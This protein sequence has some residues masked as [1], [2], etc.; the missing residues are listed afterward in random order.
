M[1]W[2]IPD[3]ERSRLLDVIDAALVVDE[4]NRT[5]PRGG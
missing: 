1:R 5:A 2:D 4:H 3:W